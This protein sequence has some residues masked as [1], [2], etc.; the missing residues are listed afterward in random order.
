MEGE[1]GDN[2][3][4]ELDAVAMGNQPMAN[5]FQNEVWVNDAT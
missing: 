4:V 2:S 1:D 5:L 3:E